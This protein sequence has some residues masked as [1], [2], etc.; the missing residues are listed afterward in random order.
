MQHRNKIEMLLFTSASGSLAPS[1]TSR[2]GCRG[3][4]EIRDRGVAIGE[5]K[6]DL[7]KQERELLRPGLCKRGSH[8]ETSRKRAE[9]SCSEAHRGRCAD[10]PPGGGRVPRSWHGYQRILVSVSYQTLYVCIGFRVEKNITYE[11][12][13]SSSMSPLSTHLKRKIGSKHCLSHSVS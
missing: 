3:A 8:K 2:T 10:G 5:P 7:W 11:S 12:P 4:P 13:C 9:G 6:K 1:N